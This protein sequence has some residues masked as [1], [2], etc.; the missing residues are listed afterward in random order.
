M[1]LILAIV[2]LVLG[3][4]VS[5]G[6]VWNI[7]LSQLTLHMIF[8]RGLEWIYYAAALVLGLKS[9]ESDRIWP[10]RWTQTFLYSIVVRSAVAGAL[11]YGIIA[12]TVKRD[13]SLGWELATIVIVGGILLYFVL[14]SPKFEFFQKEEKHMP[15]EELAENVV[16]VEPWFPTEEHSKKHRR[17]QEHDDTDQ[18]Q[19]P[20]SHG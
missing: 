16:L 6:D 14:F 3:A 9:L 7:P 15:V 10:W 17:E 5:E 20:S 12:L 2:A 8:S 13:I 1:Y 19:R 11:V 18:K 4:S